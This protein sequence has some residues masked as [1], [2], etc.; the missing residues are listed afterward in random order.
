MYTGRVGANGIESIED[1]HQLSLNDAL[2]SLSSL[3][4]LSSHQ[5]NDDDV[6]ERTTDINEKNQVVLPFQHMGNKMT[7]SGKMEDFL[8]KSAGGKLKD[9]NNKV[10][11]LNIKWHDL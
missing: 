1:Y 7:A 5:Q 10:S 8:P 4:P 2:K 9:K 6:F 11:Y 3:Q